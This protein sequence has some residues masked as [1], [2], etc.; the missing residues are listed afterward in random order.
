MVKLIRRI[1]MVESYNIQ[2]D[3][4]TS[5]QGKGSY[6]P[7]EVLG[8][9]NWGAFF[10]PWIWGIGNFVWLALIV[11]LLGFIPFVGVIASLVFCIWL[12]IKGN[13]LAWQS[14]QWISIYHFHKVQK[15][16]AIA[17]VAVFVLSIVFVVI[18]LAGLSV[19]SQAS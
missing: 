3:E 13:E 2:I 18:T 7:P 6:V 5:G 12:G 19:L 15:T 1:K 17:G 16:W 11:L 9:F 10:L 14:K 4:N 8:K